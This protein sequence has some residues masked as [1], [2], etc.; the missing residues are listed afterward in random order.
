MT[1]S[2]TSARYSFKDTI[3]IDSD[4]PCSSNENGSD[5]KIKLAYYY[6]SE[7]KYEQALN[8]YE[9]LA[10]QLGGN[11]FAANIIMCK[12]KLKDTIS[13]ESSYPHEFYN[14]P[15]VSI[16]IPVYN[17]TQYLHECIN[18]V[19]SQT[20]KEIEIIIL[21]DGST[22]P[23]AVEI[24]NEYAK[25]DARIKLINKKN[26]GYGHTM[27]VGLDNA[28]G[29]YVG[30]VESD[31]YVLPNTYEFLYNTI[32]DIG[33]DIVKSTLTEF[34][35]IDKKRKFRIVTSLEDEKD[36]YKCIT[37]KDNYK[38][39]RAIITNQTCI[40]NRSFIEANSIRFNETPGSAFQD[41]GFHFQTFCLAKK[42]YFIKESFYM[43]RED[44][45]LS[46][47]N[48]KE[49]I[50]CTADEYEFIR[51]FLEKNE[52]IFQYFRCHYTLRKFLS[53][54]FT[55]KRIADSHKDMYK[56]FF[57][58]EMRKAL[59]QNE[60]DPKMLKKHELERLIEIVGHN[61]IH[62][63]RKKHNFTKDIKISIVIPIYN[64]EKYLP[65]CLDSIL[66][67]SL[68]EIEVI[69]VN[70]GS[71]D[72]SSTLLDQYASQDCRI[73]I[74]DK[75]NGGSGSARNL[76]LDYCTGEYIA[77][78]DADDFYPNVNSLEKLYHAAKANNLDVVAGNMVEFQDGKL[79]P[80]PLKRKNETVE[81]S[82]VQC[83]YGYTTYLY[84]SKLLYRYSIK[85]PDYRRY[86][87]PPFLVRALFAA[88]DITYIDYDVYAYRFEK[89]GMTTVQIQELLLGLIDVLEFSKENNLDKLHAQTVRRVCNDYFE[90][91]K[92]KSSDS[93]TKQRVKQFYSSVDFELLTNVC[94]QGNINYF[95]RRMSSLAGEN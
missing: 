24:L 75:I 30:I 15:K 64:N 23:K 93:K 79:K 27:N 72:M 14:Q 1:F 11:N 63:I 21:N 4:K 67:Q 31:D 58:K 32:V 59:V 80:S 44:N 18:S 73:S 52:E 49:K 65:A 95:H 74:L 71:T 10:E 39:F 91:I 3:N 56:K 35:D 5:S 57:S 89:K 33:C 76:G 78:M 28:T 22:D 48:S 43:H 6:F 2:T 88:R 51:K 68:E 37:P 38:I 61:K 19:I 47:V 12:K 84:K 42:I 90:R 81:Y 87:D 54:S 9:E 60:L 40:F 20:L 66:K 16:L 86:Q 85:F 29:S 17:N 8:L 50:F 45:P 83:D 69:C 36:Y 62:Y 82:E 70:D 94:T 7:K 46:S 13:C 34:S 26:T 77:F 55:L 41:N 25:N 53:F 92:N